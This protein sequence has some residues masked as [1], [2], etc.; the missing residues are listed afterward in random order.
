MGTV[1]WRF[2]FLPPPSLS[3]GRLDTSFKKKIMSLI[4][5][6]GPP[7]AGPLLE[8]GDWPPVPALLAEGSRLLSLSFLLET[9]AM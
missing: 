9:P 8:A 4:L 1:Y 3:A 7:Q 6:P 2:V 5:S